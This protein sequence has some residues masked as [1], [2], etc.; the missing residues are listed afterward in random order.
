MP[1]THRLA[2]LTDA[3]IVRMSE[4]FPDCRVFSVDGDFDVYR[5]FRNQKIPTVDPPALDRA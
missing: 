1:R 4:L 2:A 5:R 3:C